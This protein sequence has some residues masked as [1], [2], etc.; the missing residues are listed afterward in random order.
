MERTCVCGKKYWPKQ[1]WIHAQCAINNPS[2]IN[3]ANGETPLDQPVIP[4]AHKID[5][6][7]RRTPN[8]RDRDKYN[9]YMRDYMRRRRAP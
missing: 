3:R 1:A 8:R 4:V 5:G 9:E 6:P 2:A 7:E